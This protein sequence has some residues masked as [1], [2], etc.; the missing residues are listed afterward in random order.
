MS[1]RGDG[2]AAAVVAVAAVALAA[3]VA[4]VAVAAAVAVAAQVSAGPRSLQR[5]SWGNTSKL[6]LGIRNPD[7]YSKAIPIYNYLFATFVSYVYTL[8]SDEN[9][10]CKN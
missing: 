8:K 7:S 10:F 6:E 1:C 2:V 5:L 3:V 4:V 9:Q